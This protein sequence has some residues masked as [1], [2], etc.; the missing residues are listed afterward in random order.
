MSLDSGLES[1]HDLDGDLVEAPAAATA[2]APGP[3][4]HTVLLPRI[5]TDPLDDLVERVRPMLGQAVDSLH[6]AAAL[7]ADGLTDRGARV[8][9]GYHD[10]FA[11]STEVFRRLGPRLPRQREAPS[12]AGSWRESLRLIGHGPLYVLPCTAFPAVLAIVGRRSL[13]LGLV[14]AGILGWVYAGV[15]SHAAYRMLGLGRPRAAG[16]ILI[17]AAV[18]VPVVGAVTGAGLVWLTG[19]GVALVAMITC[20]VA[21]QLTST[22]MVFYRRELWLA[23]IMT[24]AFLIGAAYLI[25]G[26]WLRPWSAA[27][28]AGC[29]VAGFVLAVVIAVGR[30][31]AAD[32]VEPGLRDALRPEVPVLW[33][34]GAYGLCSAVLLLHAEAPYL[35]G[36]LDVA[37]AAAP[38]LLTMGFIEWRAERFRPQAVALMRR[39]E[40]PREFVRGVWRLLARETAI[41][42]LATAVPAAAMLAG[43]YYL[44]LLSAA[45]VVM[46]AAHVAL[47]G[48]YLLAFQLAGRERF[49]W[50]C[51]SML[52]AIVL[53]VVAGGVLG[54]APLLGQ[55]GSA[56]VDTSLY[57]ASVLLVQALFVLG[58]VPILGQAVRYR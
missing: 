11:L 45:G 25:L 34:V 40:R 32:T 7:E 5:S 17:V 48:A 24:P 12:R 21:Y 50:L 16:R 13:V 4:E 3:G 58:L 26:A 42:L 44:D 30:A 18:T 14:F 23:L 19:G 57:L 27:M 35:L 47:G 38:L 41:C 56:L 20:Q 8:E 6:V 49:G 39:V 54:V 43:L 55:S 37:I 33:A 31:R 51:A 53:H 22:V 29:V 36:R 28:A 1:G 2:T 9:Y 46:T 15:A 52:A 10:V